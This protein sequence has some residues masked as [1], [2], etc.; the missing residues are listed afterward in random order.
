MEKKIYTM[1]NLGWTREELAVL[2][3]QASHLEFLPIVP[4]YYYVTRGLQNAKRGVIYENE[5]ARELLSEWNI[6]IN[7]ELLRKRLEFELNN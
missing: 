3:E 1:E 6:K 7:D 5:N 2:K 4:G